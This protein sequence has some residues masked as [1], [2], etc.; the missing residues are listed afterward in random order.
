MAWGTSQRYS[1]GIDE[2]QR[3]YT[4]G[5]LTGV[6]DSSQQITLACPR[7][8]SAAIILTFALMET[9]ELDIPYHLPETRSVADA[10]NR[11]GPTME[12]FA[13]FASY[14]TPLFADTVLCNLTPNLV[15]GTFI[16]G[17]SGSARRDQEFVR[18]SCGPFAS[19]NSYIPGSLTGLWE[20]SYMVSFVFQGSIDILKPC[21][22]LLTSINHAMI[23]YLSIPPCHNSRV[24]SRCS[25]RS[26][27][28]CASALTSPFLRLTLL[29]G[30][31]R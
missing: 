7:P 2:L 27:S 25:A 29:M 6:T 3:V 4:D 15:S 19:G 28:T 10:T 23:P 11:S 18:M 16:S 5:N 24:G 20:G 12:D 8:S 26:Q 1:S 30:W 14:R 13:K 21:H 31:S 17:I 22:R 9:V